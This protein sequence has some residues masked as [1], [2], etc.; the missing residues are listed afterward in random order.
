MARK[1]MDTTFDSLVTEISDSEREIML[2]KMKKGK[3]AEAAEP[4][5]RN[6]AIDSDNAEDD[7]L[8]KLKQQSLLKQLWIWI[9][10]AL[11]NTPIEEVFN[12]SL[13]AT[14]AREIEKESPGIIKWKNRTLC[15]FFYEGLVQLKTAVE[16]FRPFIF[17]YEKDPSAFYVLLGY[18]IMPEIGKEIERQSDPYQYS[19]DKN[20]TKEMRNSLLT[21]MDR[22]LDEIPS[23]K[24]SEMYAS[25]RFLE[26]LLQF[27][28]LPIGKI[29]AKFTDSA[30]GVKECPFVIAKGDFSDLTKVMVNYTP[31][32]DEAVQT[33][34]LN[35]ERNTKF[36]GFESIDENASSAADFQS[37]ASTQF[38]VIRTFVQSVSFQKL[39]KVVFENSQYVPESY[40]GGEDWFIKFKNQWRALFDRRWNQWNRDYKKE[41]IKSKLL[42]Y[43][44]LS[45]FPL[46]PFRPWE[47]VFGSGVP[48]HYDL[49]MGFICAFF[50]NEF[51]RYDVILEVIGVE[52]DFSL[53][54]NRIEFTDTMNLFATTG[55]DV[56]IFAEKLSSTGEYGVQLAKYE[57][58]DDRSASSKDF[59]AV[60]MEEIEDEASTIIKNFGKACRSMSNLL[61]GILS[62]KITAYYGPLTN[63]MKIRGREN[64]AFREQLTSVKDGINHAYELIKEFESIDLEN[65]K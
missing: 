55:K 39:S 45:T 56:E 50:R 37:D 65:G 4:K 34:F 31:I 64:K 26:W 53:R 11:T 61:A 47:K 42:V 24:K 29:A 10:S 63:L 44:E 6:E 7:L 57:D 12:I 33:L 14:L 54:E 52:G 18:V 2:N 28:K 22:I 41:K 3:T 43:F 59:I 19:F 27:A 13:V 5:L 21:K 8:V 23:Q 51:K 36:L 58:G 38:G 62:E 32:T 9:K 48:F 16:F 1:G 49:T 30:D 15:N 25:V 20:V 60:V 35:S 40:G 17:E 46:F